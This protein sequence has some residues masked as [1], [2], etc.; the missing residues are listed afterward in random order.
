MKIIEIKALP[1]GAHNNQ[2]INGADPTTFPVPDGWAVIHEDDRPHENFPFG[3]FETEAVDGVTYMKRNSWVPGVIP[4]P[5][6]RPQPEPAES[7]VWDEM[8]A[9]YKEGV[10]EA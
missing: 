9:A 5:E 6:Q 1:N 2:T 7:T 8:A 3:S 10:Q 4:E